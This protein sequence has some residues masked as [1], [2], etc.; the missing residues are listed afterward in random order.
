MATRP[1]QHQ[2]IPAA[3][4]TKFR[5]QGR[6]IQDYFKQGSYIK[7][8]AAV[9]ISAVTTPLKLLASAGRLVSD[10]A[11]NVFDRDLNAVK[12]YIGI[13]ESNL[14]A[15]NLNFTQIKKVYD[16]AKLQFR[17]TSDRVNFAAVSK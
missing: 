12:A 7:G 2:P 6:W 5:G 11:Y 14:P 3:L 10:S 1:V 9:A 8:T 13:S 15:S 16:L 4:D 17:P